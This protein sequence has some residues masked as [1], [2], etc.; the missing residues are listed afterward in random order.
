MPSA[1][2]TVGID[3]LQ[4]LFPEI[5]AESCGWDP[6]TVKAGS[7]FLKMWR[8]HLGH[9]YETPVYRRTQAGTG[10]TYCAGK[11]VLAGFNDLKHNYPDIAAE[12]FGWDPSKVTFGSNKKKWW[13]CIKEHL[14]QATIKNRVLAQSGCPYCSG[15]RVLIGFNDLRTTHPEFSSQAVGWEPAF[16]SFGSGEKVQWICD[17]GHDHHFMAI[18]SNRT[19]NGTGCSIC[20]GKEVLTGFND[21]ASQ[22]PEIAKE[23][24]GW[25]ASRVAAHSGDPY[26][27]RCN[28]GHPY[29]AKVSSRTSTHGTGCPY[30]SGRLAWKGFNDL[31][32]LYPDIAAEADGWDP[33]QVTKGCRDKKPWRCKQ[34]GHKWTAEVNSRTPPHSSGCSKCAPYGFD[35]SI[36]GW[37]Y[38]MS[39]PGEQQIGITNN[40]KQRIDQHKKKGWTPVDEKGPFEGSDI[41]AI[42]KSLKKWL[43]ENVGVIDGT[44]ENWTTTSMEVYSLT[45]LKVKSGIETNLF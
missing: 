24:D 15:N 39:R 44:T 38:L 12:A 36:D 37:I 28:F 20:S 32:K 26:P 23:A 35:T 9:H 22:F 4:T 13:R 7:N 25:D 1:K 6:R 29:T 45:E 11:A 34:C 8:C 40:L 5:A 42:E 43:K 16:Y 41:L 10:C 17:K 14:F 21:L 27:W 18:I 3:D 19:L 30:C 31:H 2:P 33:S